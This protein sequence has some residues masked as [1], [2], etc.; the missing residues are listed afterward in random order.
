MYG[1]SMGL[2][3]SCVTKGVNIVC[4]RG[5]CTQF[6]TRTPLSSC[7]GAAITMH[8]CAQPPLLAVQHIQH[9]FVH[10]LSGARVFMVAGLVDNRR[11]GCMS[12]QAKQ[13]QSDTCVSADQAPQPDTPTTPSSKDSKDYLGR[14]ECSA[15]L[16]VSR[17]HHMPADQIAGMTAA[18]DEIASRAHENTKDRAA[19][20][21]EGAVGAL[22]RVLQLPA[23]STDADQAHTVCLTA[24]CW[25]LHCLLGHK[26]VLAAWQADGGTSK[27]NES[28]AGSPVSE[29][30]FGP[31]ARLQKAAA[32]VLAG[33]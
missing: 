31:S 2:D 28:P 8:C 3:Y 23:A 1:L 15:Q 30:Q 17:L 20:V 21:R 25:A 13:R 32:V 27:D 7:A 16:L 24:V 11:P 22:V 29:L 33:K 10:G 9:N 4:S 18:A 6:L 12:T 5:A 19:L 26:V 14:Q